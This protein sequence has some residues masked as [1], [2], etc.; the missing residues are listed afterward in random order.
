MGIQ[1]IFNYKELIARGNRFGHNVII[2]EETSIGNN[3]VFYDNCIIKR[4]TSVGN[5]NVF[6]AGTIMGEL[7][8]EYITGSYK[9]KQIL[10]CPK[11]T[12][13]NGNLFET[14]SVVQGALE[15]ETIIGNRVCVGTHSYIAHDVNIYDDVIICSHCTVAGYCIV[16][17]HTN[18][19]MGAGIH[20]R[21][22]L[23]AFSMIGAGAVVVKHIAPASIVKG[24]PASFTRCNSL[25]L[26]RNGI[27]KAEI[28]K[29]EEWLKNG[30]SQKYIPE[31]IEKYY[32][33]FNN[34]I[35]V[36]G[37]NKSVIPFR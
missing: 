31:Y 30:C 24:V 33:K 28:E 9:K 35:L 32:N 37:S 21:I 23:G 10:N 12:I 26:E 27:L 20:Q 1:K 7:P 16:L 8:R 25:G 5:N 2:E 14:Y 11:L 4:G 18:I 15:S 13:G 36:W 34:Q 6:E 17:E 19:G 29:T 22:V 3:N